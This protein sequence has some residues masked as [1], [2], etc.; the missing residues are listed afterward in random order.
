MAVRVGF[1][2]FH[3]SEPSQVI[4]S[5]NRQKRQNRYLSQTE[6]HGGYT[7]PMAITAGKKPGQRSAPPSTSASRPAPTN[8]TTPTPTRTR[9]RQEVDN[10]RRQL[11]QFCETQGWEIVAEYV[12]EE[13]A[14]NPTAPDFST[15]G[16]TLPSVSLTYYS[17]GP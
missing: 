2:L 5:T 17:F 3:L 15:C 14:R 10:Q 13:S 11:R 8:A 6:V 4:E 9:K 16:G 7:E 1:E 12:D